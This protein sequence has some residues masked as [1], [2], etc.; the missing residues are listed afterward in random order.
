MSTKTLPRL[1]NRKSLAA[2]L[3]ITLSAAE[4]IMREVPKVKVGARVFVREPDVLRH[5][6]KATSS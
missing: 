3:G 1:F 4:T 2:E 5:L 6:R